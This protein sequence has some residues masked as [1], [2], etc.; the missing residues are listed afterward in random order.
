[1]AISEGITTSANANTKPNVST[2]KI[3]ITVRIFVEISFIFSF[4]IL[5]RSE[6]LVLICYCFKALRQLRQLLD[7]TLACLQIASGLHFRY[8]HPPVI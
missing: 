5:R 4:I 6:R 2:D 7:I 1:M 8:F 3:I